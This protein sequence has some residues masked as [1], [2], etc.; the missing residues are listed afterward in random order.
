MIF[1][2]FEKKIMILDGIVLLVCILAFFRGWKKGLLWAVVSIIAVLIGIIVSLKFSHLLANYLFENDI[3]TNSYTLLIS[4]VILFIGTILIFRM[5]I[6]F[7]EK[8]LE[9]VFLGWVNN[10]LGG[11]IYSF[12]ILFLF[13]TFFWLTNKA[14][15]LKQENKNS[16]KV[17]AYIE[18]IAPKTV[19]FVTPYIPFFKTLYN[20]IELYFEKMQ[21]KENAK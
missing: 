20:D 18:P 16:S 3:L 21:K 17:Y 11:L 9:I 15:L 10:A 4:F 2:I 5:A 7:L 1:F 19:A 14:N 8:I 12:F 6:K 13:S